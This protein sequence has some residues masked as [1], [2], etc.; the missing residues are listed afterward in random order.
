[1]INRFVILITLVSL[2]SCSHGSSLG[3][4]RLSAEEAP[5]FLKEAGKSF[6]GPEYFV[7]RFK[8]G[9][10][11]FEVKEAEG[12]KETSVTLDDKGIFLE[13]EEDISITDLDKLVRSYVVTYIHDEYPDAK[14]IELEKRM[15]PNNSFIDVEIRHDSSPSGYWEL[16]FD[17]RGKFVS[18]EIENYDSP[19]THN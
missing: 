7:K 19:M 11:V 5:R 14:I 2:G 4:E 6:T 12:E 8:Y 3:D 10:E 15:T 1:M 13:R 18:R 9:K 16:S 17:A